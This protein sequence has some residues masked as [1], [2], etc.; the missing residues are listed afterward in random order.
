LIVFVCVRAIMVLNQMKPSISGP[1]ETV[2]FD[3]D[4][5][6]THQRKMSTLPSVLLWL[7][8]R[9][10]FEAYLGRCVSAWFSMRFGFLRLLTFCLH[11][12]I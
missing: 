4:F 9:N 11:A 3:C 2:L 10:R 5:C 6:I 12:F 1:M 8:G 7:K